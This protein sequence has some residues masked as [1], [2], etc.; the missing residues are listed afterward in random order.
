MTAAALER[1]ARRIALLMVSLDGLER[2]D[3]ATALAA[4][5]AARPTAR[6]CPRRRSVVSLDDGTAVVGETEVAVEPGERCCRWWIRLGKST[7]VRAIAGLWPW[8]SGSVIFH[9]IGDYSCCRTGLRAL[10][11]LRRA[12]AYPARPT[13]GTP[14]RSAKPCTRSG[15]ISGGQDRGRRAM[16]PDTV[17]RRETAPCLCAAVATQPDIVALDEAHPRSTKRARTR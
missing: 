9:P 7:L 12:V 3:G 14:T 11:T 13:T 4:S 1:C 17:R 15:S 6:R 5:S 8:G 16:G 10:G 2:A